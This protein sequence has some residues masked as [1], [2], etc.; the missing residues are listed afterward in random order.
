WGCPGR[1]AHPLWRKEEHHEPPLR[2]SSCP[3]LIPHLLGRI[4]A[5]TGPG[6]CR[7]TA[8]RGEEPALLEGGR[9]AP[10]RLRE[11]GRSAR[12]DLDRPGRQGA[13]GLPPGVYRRQGRAD[14]RGPL[15]L[16]RR[17]AAAVR[18]ARL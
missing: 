10:T 11:S 17:L 16:G 2:C 18:A 7:P 3:R 14:R 15:Y 13:D 5:A 1:T 4:P 12:V 6:G 8:H 9:R